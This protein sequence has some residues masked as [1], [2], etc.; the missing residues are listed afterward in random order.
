[1][2]I[3]VFLLSSDHSWIFGQQVYSIEK[4]RTDEAMQTR[5]SAVISS[6]RVCC[7]YHSKA[8]DSGLLGYY[9]V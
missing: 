3:T 5:G 9:T 1:M 7:V 6:T 4:K 2:P 8:K